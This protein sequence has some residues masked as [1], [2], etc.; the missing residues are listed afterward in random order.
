LWREVSVPALH[1]AGMMHTR[2]ASLLEIGNAV[3][4]IQRLKA[5]LPDFRI[6]LILGI[7]LC[8]FLFGN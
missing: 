6:K 5:G 3:T 7:L 1:I 8:T 2:K 4:S